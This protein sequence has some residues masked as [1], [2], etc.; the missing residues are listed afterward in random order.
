MKNATSTQTQP[1]EYIQHEDGSHEFV[2]HANIKQT[3]AVSLDM[4]DKI[5]REHAGEKQ[6]L[7]IYDFSISGFPPIGGSFRQLQDVLRKHPNHP[8]SRVIILHNS[9]GALLSIFE[10]F[11]NLLRLTGKD[12]IRY[13]LVKQRD[14]ALAWLH[15]RSQG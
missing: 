2:Y 14:E 7:F 1:L 11:S 5:L 3:F 8:L 12:K 15:D 10:S 4:L 13:F 6:L 9:S